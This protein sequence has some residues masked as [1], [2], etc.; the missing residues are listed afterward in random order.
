MSCNMS[1]DGIF[2]RAITNELSLALKGGRINKIQQPFPNELLMV[3]RANGKNHRLLLSIHPSYAR[4]Q[5]TN[6]VYENPNE[7]P[8]FC[9]LMRKHLEGFILEDISQI[10]LD[11]MIVF[12]VKGRNE[13]GDISCKQLIVEI[14]GRHSNIILVDKDRN[15]IL[16][17]IKHVSF[18]VN[19]HR[20][21][22]PGQPYI[23]PPAQDKVSPFDLNEEAILRTLDFNAGKLD[24]QLVSN[25]AGVSPLLAKEVVFQAGIANRMSLPKT[26]TTM[27]QKLKNYDY[28]P[29]I[30]TSKGKESFYLFPLEHLQGETKIFP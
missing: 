18:A 16:D 2:T 7:P 1:F 26:F 11:R 28:S 27:F 9:M 13:L 30:T 29:A 5:L 19:S 10:S 15:M 22:L 24:Q 8:M 4:V 23:L 25:F 3:I 17:S 12:E 6:E 20:A 14:M 21:I